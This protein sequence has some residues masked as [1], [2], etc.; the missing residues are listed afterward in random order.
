MDTVNCLAIIPLLSLG[1]HSY[2][3]IITICLFVLHKRPTHWQCSQQTVRHLP[4]SFVQ[5][6]H[7]TL[8][9]NNVMHNSIS[10]RV[11]LCARCVCVRSLAEECAQYRGDIRVQSIR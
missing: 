10:S 4:H 6:T 1:M 11:T 5:H 2:T 9:C 8:P 7:T 3:S